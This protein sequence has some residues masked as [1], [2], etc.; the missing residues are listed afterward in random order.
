MRKTIVIIGVIMVLVLI[1]GFS[2]IAP[3]NSLVSLDQKVKSSWSQVENVYQR[4]Y[5]LIDNLVSTVQ[6]EANFEK[7]TFVE[8]TEARSKASQITID[9]TKMTQENMDQFKAAQGQLSSALGRLLVSVEQYPQLKSSQAF[10]E[11]RVELAGSQ[12][13]ITTEIKTFND[14]T[15]K[16]NAK[17]LTFPSNMMAKMFGFTEKPYFKADVEVKKV[18]KVKMDIK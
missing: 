17:V 8:V 13:R 10:S 16:Y 6:S 3:Y 15:E 9:P 12:N 4:R 2:T 7:S 18:P 5:E 11:L 1:I 14:I